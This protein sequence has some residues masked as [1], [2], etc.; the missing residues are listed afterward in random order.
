MNSVLF[1]PLVIG[2]VTIKNRVVLSP[3]LQH[4][5]Q[6]GH[7]NDWH[8]MHLG[9]FAAGGVGLVFCESTK[10]DPRGCSTTNDLGLWK[11]EFIEP[12]KRI[13]DLI[14]A[15]GAIP[16][17]QLSHSGRKARLALPWEGRV[18]LAECLGVDHGEQWELIG[19]SAIAHSAKYAIPRAMTLDDIQFVIDA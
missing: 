18:P 17:I 2:D 19:P 16:G 7:V 15:N 6:G 13:T 4:S 14:K 12:L 3:M 5:A 9:K 1:S 8:L 11:D 10:V